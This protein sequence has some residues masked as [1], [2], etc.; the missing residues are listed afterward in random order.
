MKKKYILDSIGISLFLDDLPHTAA[1]CQV[2]RALHPRGIYG[3]FRRW[4]WWHLFPA[5]RQVLCC[6][7]DRLQQLV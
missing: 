5:Q 7:R 6:E 1:L 4:L 3:W 2:G